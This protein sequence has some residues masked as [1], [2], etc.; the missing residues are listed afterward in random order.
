MYSRARDLASELRRPFTFH[1]RISD[2]RILFVLSVD[3]DDIKTNALL[4]ERFFVVAAAVSAAILDHY[5]G[6]PVIQQPTPSAV[7][8]IST[9]REQRI[10]PITRARTDAPCRPITRR[11]ASEKRSSR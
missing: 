3:R 10:S 6:A 5:F 2:H 1:A 4:R 9:A 7:S 11:I 8:T